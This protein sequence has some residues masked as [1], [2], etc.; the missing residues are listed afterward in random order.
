MLYQPLQCDIC[1]ENKIEEEK[2][3]F[4]FFFTMIQEHY[5]KARLPEEYRIVMEVNWYGLL[6]TPYIL[7][8]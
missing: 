1:T 5:S 4:Y 7:R 6:Y 3:I 2:E 8:V